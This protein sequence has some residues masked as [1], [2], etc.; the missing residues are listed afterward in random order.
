MQLKDIQ[1]PTGK[2]DLLLGIHE[3]RLFPNHVLHSHDNLLLC[4]SSFG[5]GLLLIGHHPYLN[6]GVVTQAHHVFEKARA[7]Y[8]KQVNHV[9]TRHNSSYPTLSN[10]I[11]AGGGGVQGDCHE[12]VCAPGMP[13]LS[14][15]GE[16]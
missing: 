11:S 13:T 12:A 14:L 4:Q 2:V 16:R 3:A 7:L 15:Q 8:G 9:L 10:P 5:S 6:P 1:R